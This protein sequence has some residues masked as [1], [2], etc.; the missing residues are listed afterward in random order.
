V[1]N[2]TIQQHNK[3]KPQPYAPQGYPHIMQNV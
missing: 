2:R 1:I 3:A